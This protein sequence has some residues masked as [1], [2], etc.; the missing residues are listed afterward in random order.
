MIRHLHEHVQ[1]DET[2]DSIE[3]G[4]PSKGGTLKVY[5]DANDKEAAEAKI[6]KAIELRTF[7]NIELNR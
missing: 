6:K 1:K 5:F 2:P 3:I 4:T 7:A